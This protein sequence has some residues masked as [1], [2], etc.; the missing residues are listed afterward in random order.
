MY[1]SFEMTK[2][3]VKDSR[4]LYEH[5]K[6]LEDEKVGYIIKLDLKRTAIGNEFFKLD[7]ATGKNPLY[8]VL[9]AY[10]QYDP[11][12]NYCQGMNFLVALL[13]K[14]LEDEE[15]AFYCLVHIMEELDWK[16]CFSVD[17]I[18]LNEFVEF[19]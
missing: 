18:K 10:A 7:P 3:V 12:I 15:D 5:Y 16:G 1:E 8:N 9:N 4:E 11:E 6:D 17:M 19:L 13:L 14:H 2:P